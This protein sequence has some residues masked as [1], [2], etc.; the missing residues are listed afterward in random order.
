MAAYPFVAS[1]RPRYRIYHALRLQKSIR[2]WP[3]P[4]VL[5]PFRP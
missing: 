2:R 1:I 5:L 3:T 4:S